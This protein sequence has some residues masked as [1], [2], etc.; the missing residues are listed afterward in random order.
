MVNENEANQGEHGQKVM[1][2]GPYNKTPKV[3]D[4]YHTS[5]SSV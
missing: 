3:K 2:K 5:Y 4:R 1:K